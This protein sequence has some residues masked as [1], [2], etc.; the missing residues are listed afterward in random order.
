MNEW[1]AGHS[2]LQEC[3]QEDVADARAILDRVG[4]YHAAHMDLGAAHLREGDLAAAERHILRALELGYPVPGLAQNHLA[5][6]AFTRGDVQGMQDHFMTAAKEDP[7][8][9]VLM[10]NVQA[11]RAWFKERGPD[12]GVPLALKVRHD[13]QLLER[14]QQPTLPGP[15]PEDFADWQRV[16]ST[17]A[18]PG[19]PEPHQV[20]LEGHEKIGFPKKRL[21]VLE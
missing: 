21:R 19:I 18:E 3:Y 20:M 9:H 17:A 1:F 6:I 16:P 5:V 4:D 15:L 12:R 10:G 11:T 13:F 7:Q 2:G 14:T 8:H